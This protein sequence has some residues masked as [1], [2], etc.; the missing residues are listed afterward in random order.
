MN[1]HHDRPYPISALAKAFPPLDP[2]QYAHL[3]TSISDR[4]LRNPIT[5]WR[6]EIIDGV[7]RLKA[8]IEAGVDPRYEFLEDDED[9]YEYLADLN[10]AFRGMTQNQKALTAHL[11]SHYSTPGRPRSSDENSANLRSFTQGEAA[12]LLG[13][14]PRLVSD[15]SRVLSEGTTAVPAV[16]EAVLRWR[17]SCSD[18][19]KVVGLPPEVQNRAMELVDRGETKTVKTAVRRV[20][21]ELTLAAEEA[22][23]LEILARPLDDTIVLH[24]AAVADLHRRVTA[25]SVDAVV[26]HPAHTEEA[27]PLLADLAAFAA[28]ALKPGG[29]MVVVGNGVILPRMLERLAHRDLEWLLESDLVFHG[30]PAGSGRPHYVRLHRRPVLVYGKGPV[31]LNGMDD[32]FEVPARD[33]LPRGIT[34]QEAAMD[35]LVERFCHPGNAICDPIM[36]D[37]AGTALA[38]RR[39]GCTFVGAS[40]LQSCIDGIRVRLDRSEK[41]RE[42]IPAGGSE[43]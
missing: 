5:V 23:R 10:I 43:A 31:R 13:V 29:V 30:D 18:A 20:E 6:G 4:G 39:L 26:T 32:L 24:T 2:A 1:K 41:E 19:S 34:E 35:L 12:K 11:M 8:C 9:P 14:S 22:T 28:H 25:G 36:L 17:V 37:R 15:A 21:K 40:K 38:A 3:L 33:A 7:H 42:D 16:Q 27:L